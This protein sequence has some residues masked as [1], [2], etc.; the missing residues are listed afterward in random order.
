MLRYV[1][2]HLCRE[3]LSEQAQEH[4]ISNFRRYVDEI[5]FLEYYAV[6][7]GNSKAKRKGSFDFLT[8]GGGTDRLSPNVSSELQLYTA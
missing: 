6:Y 2:L 5:S 1:V 3:H 7:S 8:L 4:V